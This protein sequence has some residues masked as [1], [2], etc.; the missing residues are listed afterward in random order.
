MLAAALF[1]RE[2]TGGELRQEAL[3]LG[4]APL[5]RWGV[6]DFAGYMRN[7]GL[8]HPKKIDEAVPANLHCGQPAGGPG[9]G[10]AA[11]SGR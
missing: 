7:L 9:D 8:P 10:R 4:A 6:D 11:P 1:G 5:L 2:L 3:L